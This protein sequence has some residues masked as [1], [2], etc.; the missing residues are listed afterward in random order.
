M[1]RRIIALLSFVLPVALAF[2]QPKQ[3]D[4][5]TDPVAAGPDFVVQGEYLGELDGRKLGAQVIAEGKG[6]FSVVFLPGGL[7]GADS[8]GKTRLKSAAVTADGI[9][10]VDGGKWKGRIA[11]GVLSGTD[12]DGKTFS[13]KKVLRKSPTEGLKPPAGALVLFDGNGV[14][15]WTGT[16]MTEDK[17]MAP[18]GTTKRTFGDMKIHVE[19][20]VPFRPASRGQSRG[21]SGVYLQRRY[22][23][24]I[25]DSFGLEPKNND[26]AAVYEV[27]P[28]DVNACYPPLSW[29]T[30]DI[31]FTAAR[32]DSAGKK[33]ANAVVTVYHNG[34]KVHDRREIK[35]PTGNGQKEEDSAKSL[36]LQNHGNPVHFRN[37]WVVAP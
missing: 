30:Y 11:D 33:T 1:N 4:T 27:T 29:Q 21:N 12:P 36:Y 19:F 24:Q 16:K 26:C 25:L 3:P 35:G 37:V 18:G 2:A 34:V 15:E 23:I 31:E 17:L 6:K 13:L 10:T 5:S 20:R 9:T 7:P 22:E 8:N 28:P 32:Y 14:D